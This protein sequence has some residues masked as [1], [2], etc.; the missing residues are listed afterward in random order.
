MRSSRTER[1]LGNFL[2]RE[3]HITNEQLV[4]AIEKSAEVGKGLSEVLVELG[5][6]D[7]ENLTQALSR[8]HGIPY[9]P[10]ADY[11]IDPSIIETVPEEDARRYKMIP[12]DRT[13]RTLTVALAD[14]GNI[15][16]LDEL[17]L[18]TKMEIEPLLSLPKDIEQAIEKYYKSD[19][20]D[21]EETMRLAAEEVDM[22]VVPDSAME[23]GD[24]DDADAAPVIRLVNAIVSQAI[25]MR[26]SDIHLEPQEHHLRLRYRLD[27]VL[28]E[29]KPLPKQMQ[30][31]VI[32]RLKIMSNL[33]ISEKRH[34]QDGRFKARHNGNTVD[35][36]VSMLPTVYGEKIVLRLLDKGNLSLD[37]A[38][39]GF[40]PE[41][42]ER[43]D[44][45]IK[46]PYGILLVTGPTGSGK[47]TTLYSA[48]S[49]INDP[50]TNITTVEDPVEFQIAGINQVQAH[51]E[52]GF[53][54]ADAL[55]SILRQDPDVVMIGEIRDRETA[56]IAIKAALTGHLVLS[57][58]HTND[59]PSTPT[60]LIDMQVEPFLVTS[61]LILVVAQRLCRKICLECKEAYRPDADTVKQLGI[62]A[63]IVQKMGLKEIV[64]YRGAG[65]SKCNGTGYKGRMALY[66]V[67]EMDDYICSGIMKGIP[68]HELKKLARQR[69]MLTLR[70]S[71]IRKVLQGSTSVKEILSVTFEN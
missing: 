24:G 54:F 46:R 64:F 6:I 7:Q 27:G 69:G 22:D 2:V 47:S 48:L 30:N 9:L 36:R 60:R 8:Q 37:M 11:D 13:E 50:E 68:P 17:K 52:I 43:F 4:S 3:G 67:M 33:D 71:G 58:I 59:A 25:E 66:E 26:A 62:D 39:L 14:P 53:T 45:A 41:S 63:S 40:E 16:V 55:R 1:S 34:P 51:T 56:E 35:F 15:L 18:K 12:V 5:L 57:T 10:L 28:Q 32:S 70:D 20:G 31:A 49:S 19:H 29:K 61:A 21:F 23:S 42:L 38:K 44:R 65:C